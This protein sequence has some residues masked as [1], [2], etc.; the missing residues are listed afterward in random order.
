MFEFTYVNDLLLAI[1]RATG[2]ELVTL[3]YT[4][5][6]LIIVMIMPLLVY[7]LLNSIKYVQTL[8]GWIISKLNRGKD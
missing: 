5:R 1:H 6:I 7:I 8:I 3:R 4:L 2:I